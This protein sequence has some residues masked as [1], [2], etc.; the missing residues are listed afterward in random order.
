MTRGLTQRQA[1]VLEFIEEF[2]ATNGYPPTVREVAANFGFRSPRA[3]HDHMKALEKKGYMRSRA[4]RPRALEILQ[5]RRGIPVLG[6]IAAGQPILAVEDAEEVLGLEPGFFGTGSFF[7]L[8][9]RGDSMINDHIAEGDLVILRA[10]DDAHKGEVA[11]VLLGD[12]VTLKHF[13]PRDEGLELRAANP[14]VQSIMVR[15]GDDP[16]RVLGVMVG[17]VRKN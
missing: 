9:V 5:S 10:Q 7:A 14:A 11:A 17:L 13:V 16:P 2:T 12:E 6:K 1:Q 15:P 4:G 3:A 8:R